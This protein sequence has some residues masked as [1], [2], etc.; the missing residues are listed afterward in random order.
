MRI[1]MLIQ[2]TENKA[3]IEVKLWTED[4]FGDEFYLGD[5]LFLS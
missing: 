4:K 3:S 5:S 1:R 2:S